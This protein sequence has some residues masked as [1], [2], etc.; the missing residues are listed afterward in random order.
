MKKQ[1]VIAL[2]ACF[3]AAPFLQAQSANM[4]VALDGYA[5]FGS[6]DIPGI[7]TSLSPNIVWKHAGDPAVVPFAGIF[8]GH[9]EVGRFFESV[10]KSIQITVFNPT[11][12]R[13]EGNKVINDTHI[14]G[15]VIS[16][17]KKYADDLTMTWTFGPDGKP[18]GWEAAGTMSG[19]MAAFVK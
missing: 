11:N 8:K 3:L 7:I 6:G 15:M 14:E 18:I 17:G 4:K 12:F 5:K 2:L 19:I 13:E 10:G 1:V 9:A 16:T